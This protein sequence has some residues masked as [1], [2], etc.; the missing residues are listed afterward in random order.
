[1]PAGV[2]HDASAVAFRRSLPPGRAEGRPEDRRSLLP[3]NVGGEPSTPS[4]GGIR[5]VVDGGPSPH[6]R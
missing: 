5:K 4:C 3:V 6:V 2:C 1:M